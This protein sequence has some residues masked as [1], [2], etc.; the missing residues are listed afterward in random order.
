VHRPRL[1]DW[2]IYATVVVALVLAARGR[3]ERIDA[4]SAPAPPGLA[5]TSV[6]PGS[7]FAAQ[8]IAPVSATATASGTAF[9]VNDRGDWITAGHVI[10]G[11]AQVGVV[12]AAGR[13]AAAKVAARL[14]D[15]ALL[16]TAG[17]AP[18]LPLAGPAAPMVGEQLFQP[19]YPQGAA[20]E[21]AARL[22]G[23]QILHPR[24][25]GVPAEPVLA[26]AQ[27]GRT[28]GLS[29]GLSG[30]SGAPVLNAFGQVVGVILAQSPRRGRLYAAPPQTLRALLAA[31]RVPVRAGP[32]EPVTVDNY[33]RAADDLR[34]DLTV[35]QVVCLAA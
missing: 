14:G 31:A 8:R 33:G 18:A 30:L 22:L 23:R 21:V 1:P 5:Q 10:D 19:G 17:G 25:R 20:G 28:E 4:P 11:C 6:A 24:G 35:V 32:G 13:G 3:Q 26:L 9:S 16:T 15:L 12:V 29:G 34:R 7:P 2:L 27:N